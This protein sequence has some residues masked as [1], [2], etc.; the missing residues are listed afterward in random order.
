MRVD[1]AVSHSDLRVEDEV[2]FAQLPLS[3]FVSELQVV[4]I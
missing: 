1:I 2:V 4:H 3:A